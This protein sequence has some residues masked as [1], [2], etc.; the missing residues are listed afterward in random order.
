VAVC[1]DGVVD[2]A[3]I[4]S[5][6][7]PEPTLFQRLYH[8]MRLFAARGPHTTLLDSIYWWYGDGWINDQGVRS[9]CEIGLLRILGCLECG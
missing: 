3:E 4:A 5:G 9:V 7:H 6:E 1:R 2:L 8:D